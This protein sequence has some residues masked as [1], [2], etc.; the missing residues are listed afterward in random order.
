MTET[1]SETSSSSSNDK[2][3]ASQ[4]TSQVKMHSFVH[5]K[6]L[7]IDKQKKIDR[8]VANMIIKDLQPFTIVE[9]TGFRELMSSLEPG[10]KLISRRNLTE[11][12]LPNVYQK[13]KERAK[14]LIENE[15]RF[16]SLTTDG[17]TSA[18]NESYIAITAHFIDKNWN[19]RSI[20]LECCSTKL[21][22]T[23]EN[24]RNIL[25]KCVQDWNI[26]KRI[27]S[28]STDNAANIVAAI[29]LT[30]WAHVPCFAHSINLV[31]QSSLCTV[32]DVITKLKSI[33]EFFHRSTNANEKLKEMQKIM[34]PDKL[35]LILKNDVITRWNS[36]Y[37]MIKRALDIQEPLQ[38]A[39]GL[40][41]KIYTYY[42]M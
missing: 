25:L 10:Y 37:Y 7:N 26:E 3:T 8:L 13:T 22:H 30:G 24:L 40:I 19:L 17:W 5:S 34:H 28:V 1:E 12:Y 2:K 31:V 38:A 32:K 6:V 20:L 14:E 39:L 29:R 18:A 41:S 36:T 16:V 27:Y 35:P 9:D 21:S 42:F 15:A 4:N 23:A 33:V 11:N